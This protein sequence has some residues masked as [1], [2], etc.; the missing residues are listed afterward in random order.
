MKEQSNLHLSDVIDLERDIGTHRLI[1]LIAGVGAG[2]NTWVN[3]LAMQGYRV[4]LITSR[5]TTAQA[6]AK[7]MG[8]DRWLDFDRLFEV[9]IEE[10]WGSLPPNAQKKVVCT[11]AHIEKYATLRYDPD[12]P[13]THIWDKFDFIIL[14]EA[15]SMTEDATFA[16]AP[17]YIQRFL[18]H[19]HHYGTHCKIIMMTGT[20]EPIDWLFDSQKSQEIV[21]TLDYF[22]QCIHMEP[23]NVRFA[24]RTLAFDQLLRHYKRQ[25]RTIY[26]ANTGKSMQELVRQ[27]EAN[28]VA[29]DDI[30]ISYADDAEKDK[31]FSPILVSKRE[32]IKQALTETERLP[33]DIKIWITTTQ[34]KEGI[35][36]EDNDIRNM[37]TESHKLADLKQMAGRLRNGMDNFV[38]IFD[39][40][41]H[42]SSSTLFTELLNKYS[43]KAVRKTVEE[44]NAQLAQWGQRA[45][46][47]WIVT[48][49]HEMFPAIRYDP[50]SAQFCLYHGRIVGEQ[51]LRR[52][53]DELDL[54]LSNYN[55]P[56]NEHQQLGWE[57]LQAWFP[58]S[59]LFAY[60]AEHSHYLREEV[61]EIIRQHG[62]LD[63]KI[64]VNERDALTD[65][66]NIFFSKQFAG[67]L[68]A[69]LRLPFK[70]LGPA[71]S[72]FGLKYTASGRNGSGGY[73]EVL[74]E[75]E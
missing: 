67:D 16:D 58:Y 10:E 31:L 45:D 20:P 37:F 33:A 32:R 69:T 43:V 48:K 19:A 3:A 1:R 23:K 4:L 61:L 55:S 27:L 12:K 25:E 70:L 52:D 68:P 17:F 60:N 11:N 15:H 57:L 53:A 71:L 7:K 47:N 51:Q 38:V 59:A 49:I 30:G 50:F 62:Y 18:N 41:G 73:I 35:S 42:P 26:F 24:P 8:A 39:V 46:M 9:D 74:S 21:H 34:N 75:D 13:K 66:L 22:H 64:S 36:I 28:G 63:R 65:E 2:K 56:C 72:K 29:E 44:Y 40:S 14:D 54:Y 5:V 6:Q